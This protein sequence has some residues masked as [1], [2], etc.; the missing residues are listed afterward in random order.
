MGWVWCVVNV[1]CSGLWIVTVSDLVYSETYHI[2]M[3]RH[4]SDVR[5]K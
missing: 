3:S 1:L 5:M 4:V 2:S